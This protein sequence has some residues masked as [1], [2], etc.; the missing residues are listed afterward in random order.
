MTAENDEV[1]PAEVENYLVQYF[2][3]T[4]LVVQAGLNGDEDE[5]EGAEPETES[6]DEGETDAETDSETED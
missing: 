6:D 2:F 4:F 1:D 5:D 3:W